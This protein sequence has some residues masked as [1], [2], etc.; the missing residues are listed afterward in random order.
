M[1]KLFG[2]I[3]LFV[4]SVLLIGCSEETPKEFKLDSNKI[5][6]EI[7]EVYEIKVNVS[8]YENPVIKYSILDDNNVIKLENN[9]IE[10]LKGGE[11]SI[12]IVL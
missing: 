11:S 2:L 10:A 5:T 3:L 8:G 6:M 4:F 9:K 1:K 12:E 7:G